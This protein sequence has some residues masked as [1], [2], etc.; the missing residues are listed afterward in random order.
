MRVATLSEN[1]LFSGTESSERMDSIEGYT[2]HSNEDRE[3]RFDQVGPQYFTHVGI[4]ILLGR[5]L[6]E[7]DAPGAP[8]VAVINET[9][10]KFYFP[11]VS[12]IGKHFNP[13]K[14]FRLEIVGVVRDA[15]DHDFRDQPAAPLLR[16]LLP[17][18]RRHFDSQ[19]RNPHAGPSRQ[20]HGRAAQHG[21]V[22]RS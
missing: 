2:P 1:G 21:P 17:A 9:M 20:R 6:N 12:P 10:A 11:G 7:R 5:D 15:K 8:R 3:A 18:D 14:E 16:F 13:D 4:P 19:F 22:L